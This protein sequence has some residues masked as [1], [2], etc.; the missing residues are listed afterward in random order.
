M[1]ANRL[2]AEIGLSTDRADFAGA[3]AAL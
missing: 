1:A 2:L 3:D